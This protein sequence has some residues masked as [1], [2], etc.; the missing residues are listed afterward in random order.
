[1]T[2]ART[3]TGTATRIGVRLAVVAA[4]AAGGT[5]HAQLYIDGYR[6]IHAIGVM[7]LIQAAASLALAALLLVSPP[8]GMPV[9]LRV[10]A[11]GVALGAL[12]GF[13]AS[14]TTGVFGFTERGLQPSP[15]ALLSVLA[16]LTVLALLAPPLLRTLTAGW[17]ARA[18]K[19]AARSG[20]ER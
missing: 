4:L 11:A 13:G 18:R 8:A 20:T 16:E 1:M 14:R 10:P 19:A 9:T 2:I 12:I 6:Y 7:F 5:V 15:Q 3:T 17:S